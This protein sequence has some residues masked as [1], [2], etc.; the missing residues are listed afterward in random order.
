MSGTSCAA[1]FLADPPHVPPQ[2]RYR[3]GRVARH[4]RVFAMNLL[5]VQSAVRTKARE[6]LVHPAS[7]AD[8]G[9]TWQTTAS[10]VIAEAS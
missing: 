3:S 8:P 1:Q 9:C 4:R 5:P 2:R 6:Y 10:H 7:A